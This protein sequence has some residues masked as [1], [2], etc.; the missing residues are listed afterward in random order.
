MSVWTRLRMF[1]VFIVAG[2]IL[3]I[4]AGYT[5]VTRPEFRVRKIVVTGNHVVDQREAIA[6]AAIPLDANVWTLDAH[7]IAGRIEAIPFVSTARVHRSFPADVDLAIT[8]RTPS[9]CIAGNGLSLTID[10]ERRVLSMTCLSTA[11]PRFSLA[12]ESTP[13]AGDF[14]DDEA[15]GRMQRDVAEFEAA[16]LRLRSAGFDRFG[17]L[18][19]TTTTGLWLRCGDDADLEKKLRL[20]EPI[21]QATKKRLQRVVG[22]DLRAP[23]TPVVTY[24]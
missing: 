7:A 20:V 3:A 5:I 17:S 8:E 11:L 18:D 1:S 10:G 22:I 14:I 13:K 16:G 23:S 9:A 4:V 12:L 19:A 21:M 6:A 2:L 24:R 15:L